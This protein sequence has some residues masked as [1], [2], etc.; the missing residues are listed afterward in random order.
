MDI[1][2]LKEYLG[3]ELYAQAEEKLA[4]VEGLRVIAADDGS[5]L[6]RARLD[7]EIAKRRELQEKL[8]ALT[9][10]AA[11]RDALREQLAAMTEKAEAA[12]REAAELKLSCVIRE[13]LARA[14]ARDIP[15]VEKLL[16]GQIREAG[17]IRE[18]VRALRQRS[19]YL[20]ED[21][22]AGLRAGF[23]GGS[24]GG[25]EHADVN[26]AIRAAAGR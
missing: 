15:L 21:A 10:A 11:E 24:T 1:G 17:E 18:A 7:E 13:E 8:D 26:G 16:S 14:G 4:A 25:R 6:P 20:F 12:Q 9:G 3:E 22:A 5:W 19:P 23:G 2:M